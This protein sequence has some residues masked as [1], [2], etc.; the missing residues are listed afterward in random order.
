M[1]IKYGSFPFWGCK[2][3]SLFFRCKL[4]CCSF[5]GVYHFGCVK[6]FGFSDSPLQQESVFQPTIQQE[7]LHIFEQRPMLVWV[8]YIRSLNL[9]W[10]LKIGRPQKETNTPNIHFQGRTVSFREGKSYIN[11]VFNT[12]KANEYH[13]FHIIISSTAIFHQKPFLK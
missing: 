9:T 6:L 3:S 10:H 11:H 2:F 12:K 8:F 7:I 13:N 5:Q 1:G 4:A